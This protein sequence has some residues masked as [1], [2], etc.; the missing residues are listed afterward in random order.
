MVGSAIQIGDVGEE[1]ERR[2]GPDRDLRLRPLDAGRRGVLRP[3]AER[4]T[5][6]DVAFDLKIGVIIIEGVEVDAE[7]PVQPVAL[8]ACLVGP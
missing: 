2:D 1:I 7:P 5:D 6:L 3:R 8:D 4:G